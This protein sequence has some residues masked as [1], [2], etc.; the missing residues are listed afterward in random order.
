MKYES[1][2]PL[3]APRSQILNAI[4]KEG[5]L[6]HPSP[7]TSDRNRRDPAKWCNFHNDIGHGTKD[8]F[9]LKNAIESLVRKGAIKKFVKKEPHAMDR[10]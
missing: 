8:C 3:T 4:M 10:T 2:A 5:L 7:M 6:E 9:S 1:Y